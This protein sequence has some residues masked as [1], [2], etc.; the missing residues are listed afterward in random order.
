MKKVLLIFT[1]LAAV[2]TIAFFTYGQQDKQTSNVE[3]LRKKHDH[4]LANSPFKETQKLSRKER[5]AMGLPPNAYNEQMWELTMDPSTGRPMPELVME[6]QQELRAERAMAR[7]VGGENSNPWVNRGP[8]NQGGRTRG[9]MFDPNDVGNSDAAEDYNRVFAGGVSGG[10][11]VNE[12]ITDADESWTLVPGIQANISVTA[13]VADPND[14]NVFYIGSGESYTT[15]QAVGRGV[16]K[17][18]DGGVTWDIV[19]GGGVTDVS[20]NGQNVNGIFYVNDI[21]VRD[22]NGVSEVY[23]AIASA[24]Y[25][26]ASS[27]NNFNGL[28]TMGL[29]QS[30]DGGS[31]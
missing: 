14:S 12:D 23:A 6:L 17:S 27:P 16:W 7:G 25:G 19:F 8:N 3:E 1:A 26:A 30:V 5:K 31:N 13:I 21:V 28:D 10:L 4:F 2:A 9:I 20:P 11:W 18:E 22:N 29:Y 15:G 24:F